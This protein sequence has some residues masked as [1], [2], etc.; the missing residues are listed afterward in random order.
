MADEHNMKG[1][2]REIYGG[3]KQSSGSMRK[4]KKHEGH[5]FSALN[6]HC[7]KFLSLCWLQ[8]RFSSKSKV[9]PIY[10]RGSHPPRSEE[11]PELPNLLFQQGL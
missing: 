9:C 7:T 6:P 8:N 11:L 3:D 4:D 5:L 10:S 2:R 1:N